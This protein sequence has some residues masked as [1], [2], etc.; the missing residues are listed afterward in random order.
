MQGR[1]DCM[2]LSSSTIL[3][4]IVSIGKFNFF[5]WCA[6]YIMSSLKI[7]C[8]KHILSAFIGKSEISHNKVNVERN[9][10]IQHLDLIIALDFLYFCSLFCQWKDLKKSF[11]CR[12]ASLKFWGCHSFF[13]PTRHHHPYHKWSMYYIIFALTS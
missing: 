5:N 4:T 8:P 12:I 11:S 6:K 13:N 7:R 9:H 10:F 3:Y 2:Y 1:Q